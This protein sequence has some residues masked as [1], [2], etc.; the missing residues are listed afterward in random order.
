[1]EHFFLCDLVRFLELGTKVL[2]LD[3]GHGMNCS[4]RTPLLYVVFIILS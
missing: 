2:L 3:T 4:E 1:M